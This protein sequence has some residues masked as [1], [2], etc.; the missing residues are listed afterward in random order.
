[1]NEKNLSQLEVLEL[2]KIFPET[3]L[4]NK[5][6]ITINTEEVD[7]NLILS[8]NVLSE[9]QYIVSKG[10]NVINLELGQKV[11]IDI[12]KLTVKVQ[13][14]NNTYETIT[15]VKIDPIKVD[16]IAYAI[17]EDRF[18]KSKFKTV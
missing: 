11:R 5:V 10:D 18:I 13:A 14:P 15:Q 17:I 2:V 7:G 1:M 16:G 4:F 9:I 8:D 6:I 12:E 3:P